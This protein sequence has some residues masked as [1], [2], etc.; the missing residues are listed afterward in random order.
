MINL[1]FYELALLLPYVFFKTYLPLTHFAI[2]LMQEHISQT[3]FSKGKKNILQKFK[4]F[5]KA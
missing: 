5:V 2:H 3:L 4:L 1:A